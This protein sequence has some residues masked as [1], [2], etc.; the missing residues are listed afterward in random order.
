MM[1]YCSQSGF[2]DMWAVHEDDSTLS[3]D[4][5]SNES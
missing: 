1:Q 3:I 2:D 4:M 5:L